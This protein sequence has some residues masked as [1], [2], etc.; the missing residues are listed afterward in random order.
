[1]EIN[2]DL[3]KEVVRNPKGQA[4][5]IKEYDLQDLFVGQ[6]RQYYAER[7]REA[8]GG[9]NVTAT[10]LKRCYEAAFGHPPLYVGENREIPIRNSLEAAGYNPIVVSSRRF[11]RLVEGLTPKE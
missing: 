8:I 4:I 3:P 7:T 1:M 6:H 5:A 9:I 11:R 10:S 2:I